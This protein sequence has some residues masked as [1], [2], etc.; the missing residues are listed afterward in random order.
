MWFPAAIISITLIT[1]ISIVAVHKTFLDKPQFSLNPS[2]SA[3]VL[4]T[5][6]PLFPLSSQTTPISTQP[7]PSS[8]PKPSLSPKPTSSMTVLNNIS[9][10]PGASLLSSGSSTIS[11][12]IN[13]KGTAPSGSSIVI[14]GRPTGSGEQYKVVV[15]GISAK[16]N[17]GWS[18]SGAKDGVRYDLFAVLKGKSGPVDIDYAASPPSTVKA[19]YQGQVFIVNAGYAMSAPSGTPSIN[20]R[21]HNDN[22]TWYA[23][24]TYPLVS[25]A[26]MYRL[27]LGTTSG[28]TDVG[29]ETKDAQTL[30]IIAK[31][32][33]NYYARYSVAS[34]S[35]PTSYQ[36]SSFSAVTTLRCP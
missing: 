29:D 7:S 10:N 14:S 33:V 18:W 21:V 17:A 16:N 12:T 34:V 19:P 35:Y 32:S 6:K 9:S 13:F 23:T 3:S 30:E 22:N 25:G 5:D 8:T 2:P 20:C 31:D 11:G 15:D 36:F 28:A 24:V 4:S 26:L 1:I 27:Q